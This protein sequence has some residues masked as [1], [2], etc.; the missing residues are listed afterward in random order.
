[1]K[2]LYL[3]LLLSL[4]I[5]IFAQLSKVDT[6]R[7]MISWVDTINLRV[8]VNEAFKFEYS[9]FVSSYIKDMIFMPNHYRLDSTKFYIS[10][11]R[12]WVDPKSVISF[13]KS[14]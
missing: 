9:S 3:L 13:I 4:P 5:I 12:I 1:M 6:T 11:Y 7:G 2:K 14:N 8:R 10:G